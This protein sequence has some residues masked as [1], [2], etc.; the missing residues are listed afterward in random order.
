[1][2]KQKLLSLIEQLEAELQTSG[3][4]DRELVEKV[5]KDLDKLKNWQP[6][7]ETHEKDLLLEAAVNFEEEHPKAASIINDIAYLLANIGI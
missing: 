5:T 1:M 2:S 6:E 7:H 3:S 4:I